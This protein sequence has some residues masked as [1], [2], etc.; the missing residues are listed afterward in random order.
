MSLQRWANQLIKRLKDSPLKPYDYCRAKMSASHSPEL[1]LKTENWIKGAIWFGAYFLDS[2]QPPTS[3]LF[4]SIV[5]RNVFFFKC[6]DGWKSGGSC[7]FSSGT[8]TSRNILSTPAPWKL[9]FL[10]SLATDFGKINVCTEVAF[11]K[12]QLISTFDWISFQ[13]REKRIEENKK[14][15]L[16]TEPKGSKLLLDSEEIQEHVSLGRGRDQS[17]SWYV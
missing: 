16:H 15:V 8:Q 11:D 7:P 17:I 1:N 4:L 9:F 12:A 10:I 5:E 6:H 13:H 2:D 3:P 14:E